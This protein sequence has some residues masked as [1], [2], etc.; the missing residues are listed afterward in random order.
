M[1]RRSDLRFDENGLI[2]AIVQDAL[3]GEVLMLAYMNDEA[4]QQTVASGRTVFWSRSREC[5]WLKGET[6]GNIQQVVDIQ[7]DCDGDS[8]LIRVEQQ[9]NACHTGERSCFHR[10]LSE[11]EQQ[12]GRREAIPS[13]TSPAGILGELFE[14]IRSRRENPRA[15]S[16]T[17]KL[18]A[19]G[20]GRILKK[21]GEEA[22][23][24]I[25]A[26]MEGEPADIVHEVSDL[27]YHV[28]VLLAFHRLRPQ[29]IYE[30]L[31]R[32]RSAK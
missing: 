24:V 2:P 13:P 5:L 1:E 27:L 23:E 7:Y 21:V 20:K 3:S 15:D 22:S 19:A 14:V 4:L 16:Y 10:P 9:G 26:S 8:L 6:S 11:D 32:R 12:E 25:I 17:S 28:L 18:L 30:E 31:R 29:A